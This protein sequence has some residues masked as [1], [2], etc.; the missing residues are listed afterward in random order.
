M[1][2]YPQRGN[3]QAGYRPAIV[4]SDGLIDP[5]HSDL[6]FVVPVT[7]PIKPAYPFHVPVPGGIAINGSLVGTPY[8]TLTG[9]ALTDHAK[10]LDLSARN[11]T[12][13]GGISPGSLFYTQVVSY[14]R[15]IL[16]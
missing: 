10:S 8:T 5:G 9:V 12:V 3:E 13:I 14:V 7:S 11:A 1:N 4:L 15:A 6:A 16:A 2:F